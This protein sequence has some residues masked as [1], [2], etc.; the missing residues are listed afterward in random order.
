[1]RVLLLCDDRFH[2]GSIPIMGCEPLKDKGFALDI[3]QDANEFD[4]TALNNYAVVIMS[5]SDHISSQDHS[6][7]RTDAVQDAFVKYVE[8]GGGLLVNHSGTATGTSTSKLNLLMG[9]RFTH[10]PPKCPVTVQ[11]LKPHSITAGVKMF[12]E[13]DEHYH[14]EILA[15]DIDILAAA[16]APPQGDESKY[17][18]DPKNNT[19]AAIIAAGY[20]RTQGKGRVCVLTPGHTAEVWHNPNFQQMLINAINWCAG[21]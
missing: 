9:C 15:D 14:L 6:P 3:I 1:M 4:P 7:W 2:P 20:V 19:P 12:C 18:T 16:Y 13:T 8:N 21:A 5:K 17:E 11:P 10:H